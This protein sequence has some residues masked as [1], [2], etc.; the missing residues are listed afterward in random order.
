[1]RRESGWMI[2]IDERILEFVREHGPA[3]TQAIAT[4][5]RI[6]APVGVVTDRIYTLAHAEL[7][8]P[9]HE[10][11]VGRRRWEIT[12]PGERY[13]AGVLDAAWQPHPRRSYWPA[14]LRSSATVEGS[15]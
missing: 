11:P 2:H 6:R 3:T 12:G 10:R 9:M 7:L 4:D 15:T 5:T 1:M 14:V 13:L 8:A